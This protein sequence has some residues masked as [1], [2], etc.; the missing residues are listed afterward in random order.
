[1]EDTKRDTKIENEKR[2]QEKGRNRKKKA[3]T[4]NISKQMRYFS[5]TQKR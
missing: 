1:M 5:K 3:D 2:R 4:H